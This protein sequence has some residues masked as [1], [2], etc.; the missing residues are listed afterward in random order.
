MKALPLRVLDEREG[1]FGLHD[2]RARPLR[3]LL[4]CQQDGWIAMSGH[5]DFVALTEPN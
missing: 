4:S 3:D 2:G 1:H 5:Q